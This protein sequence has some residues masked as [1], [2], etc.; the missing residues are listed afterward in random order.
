[1]A[2][3]LTVENLKN[4]YSIF[5]PVNSVIGYGP[6]F[7]AALRDLAGKIEEINRGD[8]D[9]HPGWSSGEWKPEFPIIKKG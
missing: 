3:I 8:N 1:M 6:T 7:P 5:C 2:S 4:G 9:N